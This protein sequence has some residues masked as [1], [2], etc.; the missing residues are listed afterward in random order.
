[1]IPFASYLAS[2]RPPQADCKVFC[3]GIFR[4]L[5]APSL[6]PLA[7]SFLALP[8]F[9]LLATILLSP[10][11]GVLPKRS[12]QSCLGALDLNG[13]YFK[14]I[15]STSKEHTVKVNFMPETLSGRTHQIPKPTGL[16]ELWLPSFC[17]LFIHSLV[18]QSKLTPISPSDSAPAYCPSS[19]VPHPGTP[20]V[21]TSASC[22]W[23]FLSHLLWLPQV[24][25]KIEE[26]SLH[27]F[28]VSCPFYTFILLIPV[29]LHVHCA[30][31][32]G[33]CGH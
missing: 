6:M 20:F 10:F 1:M 11:F 17:Y 19:T 33:R 23:A 15:F 27:I 5:L 22:K 16:W 30:F 32:G 18:S 2:A 26:G 13:T 12:H 24:F 4:C 9:L 31:L 14:H 25:S 3:P 29:R 7:W 28:S 8:C 21:L